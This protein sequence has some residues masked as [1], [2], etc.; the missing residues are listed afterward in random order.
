[1]TLIEEAAI[2]QI[3]PLISIV[4]MVY[5]NIESKR[6]TTCM[7]NDSKLSNLLPN[8]PSKCQYFVLS[9]NTKKIVLLHWNEQNL[10]EEKYKKCLELL[11]KV[12]N[13]VWKTT[14]KFNL[15]IYQEN[16]NG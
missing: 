10:I 16:L 2:R 1:M 15:T 14:S 9:Y 5:E 11:S 8:L 6:N 12:V 3:T 13:D 7:W 4:K